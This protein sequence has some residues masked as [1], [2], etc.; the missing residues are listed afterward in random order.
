MP[1]KP[2][3][4]LLRLLTLP[5]LLMFPSP[6]TLLLRPLSLTSPPTVLVHTARHLVTTPRLPLPLLALPLPRVPFPRAPLPRLHLL[7]TT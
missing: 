4:P 3:L 5:L 6:L 7:A 2:L 1:L